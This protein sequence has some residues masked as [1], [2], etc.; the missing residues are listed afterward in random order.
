MEWGYNRD[1]EKLPQINI[2]MYYGEECGLPLYYRIYPGSISDKAH[3]KYMAASNG[4]IDNRKTRFVMDRGFYSGENLRYLTEQGCR[5][6]IA[7][8]GSLKYCTELVQKHREELI[9]HS[10]YRLGKGLPYGKAF[11]TKVLGFR[12]ESLDLPVPE[13]NVCDNSC[14]I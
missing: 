3:L 9:N 12:F 7:L 13:E 8:P 2:G 1:K 14:G 11:E 4:L 10:E 5:F 6:V